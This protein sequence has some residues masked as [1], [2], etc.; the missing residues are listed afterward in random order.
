MRLRVSL[1]FLLSYDRDFENFDE[2]I[3]PKA[4]IKELGL[5][6]AASEY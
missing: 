5:K 1:D 2:Y 4:F 6:T 3:T